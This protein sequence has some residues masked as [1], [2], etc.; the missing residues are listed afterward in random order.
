MLPNRLGRLKH[1]AAVPFSPIPS[2]SPSTPRRRAP[3]RS[4]RLQGIKEWKYTFEE[5][6]AMVTDKLKLH[7]VPDD[8][9]IHLI[10]RILRGYDSIF[11]AGTG[12]GK[13]L[14][15]E[16][17]AVL[18][19][20]KKVTIIIRYK[21]EQYS[22]E[23]HTIL[24]HK[25]RGIPRSEPVPLAFVLWMIPGDTPL[26]NGNF[27]WNDFLEFGVE[28]WLYKKYAPTNDPNHPPQVLPLVDIKSQ[29]S[30]GKIGFTIPPLWITTT[31]DRFPTSFTEYGDDATVDD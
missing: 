9:Q 2:R 23:I 4:T 5:T 27:M 22:G 30:R 18:G 21:G 31:M 20:R 16:A 12:Y 17:V 3:P 11:L 6:R 14:I 19:G 7:Y 10:I 15:F 24:Q 8:W 29:I 25:Q 1:P 13:S 26:D 28:T